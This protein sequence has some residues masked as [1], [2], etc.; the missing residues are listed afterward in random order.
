MPGRA[1]VDRC[2]AAVE[3]GLLRL[4]ADVQASVGASEVD[5]QKPEGL[6]KVW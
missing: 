4:L 1:A 2:V 6:R 3:S 5:Q